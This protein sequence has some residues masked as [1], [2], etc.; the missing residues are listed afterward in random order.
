MGKSYLDYDKVTWKDVVL[1]Y[2]KVCGLA[3][4]GALVGCIPVIVVINF[5]DWE[6]YLLY[7]LAGVGAMIF[8]GIFFQSGANHKVILSFVFSLVSC[9]LS[10]L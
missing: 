7:F 5:F 6:S 4:G 8:Y 1:R 10:L 2:L 9:F 3:L